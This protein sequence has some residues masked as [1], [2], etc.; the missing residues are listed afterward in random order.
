L[1]PGDAD[2]TWGVFDRVALDR[3]NQELRL[4]KEPFAAVWFSLSSHAPYELPSDSYRVTLASV[5]DHRFMD[6]IRYS[7]ESLGWF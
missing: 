2:K 3:L 6:T 5:P 1:K 4:M 7:D